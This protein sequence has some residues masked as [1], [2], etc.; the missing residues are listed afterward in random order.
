MEAQTLGRRLRSARTDKTRIT[1]VCADEECDFFFSARKLGVQVK[2]GNVTQWEVQRLQKHTC[3][4][5]T[6]AGAGG[7]RTTS[8]SAALMLVG[9]IPMSTTPRQVIT[10]MKF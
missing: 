9:D 6:F 5:S 10:L 8:K 1:R 7:T 2:A 4:G 3:I